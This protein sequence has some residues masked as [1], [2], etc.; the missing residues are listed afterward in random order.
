MKLTQEQLNAVLKNYH[1]IDMK[2]GEG[3]DAVDLTMRT[4]LV[5]TIMTV[6]QDRKGDDR[7]RGFNLANKI[8][9]PH[10]IL[11]LSDDEIKLITSRADESPF[12]K[13][14]D[15]LYGQL[16]QLLMG[17]TNVGKDNGDSERM[18]PE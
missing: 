16:N 7:I 3:K 12:L 17:G 5:E 9:T 18:V 10:G 2:I 8:S 1:G 13:A 11:E 14:N 4:V 15:F 6:D